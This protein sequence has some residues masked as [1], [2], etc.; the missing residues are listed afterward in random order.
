MQLQNVIYTTKK[1]KNCIWRNEEI[2]GDYNSCDAN[3]K[4]FTKQN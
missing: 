3:N 2:V 4:I 1:L